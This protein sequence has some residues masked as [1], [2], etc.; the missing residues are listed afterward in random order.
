MIYAENI[1]LCIA[2]PLL[3]SIIFIKGDA[4]LFS[5]SFLIGMSV[6]L[7]SAYISGFLDLVTGMGVNDTSVFLSPIV[8]EIMKLLPLVFIIVLIE[9][10]DK[11]TLITAV[12]IGAGFATFENCC[13][14]LTF[15]VESFSYV[16]IRGMAVGIMHVVSL[17]MLAIGLILA[18]HF[19]VMSL[20]AVMG[21]LS[22]S[23]TFHG[24]YNLLVSSPGISSAVGYAM[25]IAA[26]A[27]L[28]LPFRKM[29]RYA[30][31]H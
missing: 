30:S 31:D 10:E 29:S 9:P 11:T 6:C 15:G 13:Y 24:L 23:V 4:R 20:P 19:D 21:A 12:G 8:E 22:L 3:L 5:A 25:P 7:I 28:Y 17:L 14:I 16:L 1:L 2:V 18:R 27:V 26:A